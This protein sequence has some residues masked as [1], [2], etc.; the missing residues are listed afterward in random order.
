MNIKYYIVLS[1]LS[2]HAKIETQPIASTSLAAPSTS[3]QQVV[4]KSDYS[5]QNMIVEQLRYVG[6]KYH[7]STTILCEVGIIE[8]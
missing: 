7:N 8:L 1:P 2:S 3:P 6:W 5:S 4:S